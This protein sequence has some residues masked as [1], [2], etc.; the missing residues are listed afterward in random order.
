MTMNIRKLKALAPKGPNYALALR[1]ALGEASGAEVLEAYRLRGKGVKA[2]E[3]LSFALSLDFL[4]Q[5]PKARQIRRSTDTKAAKRA[6]ANEQAR[7][8]Y[9]R[10]F[11]EGLNGKRRSNLVAP[12][13]LVRLSVDEV[14]RMTGR[15]KD[16]VLQVR[17]AAWTENSVPV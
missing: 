2:E 11:A 13:A 1:V 8:A 12:E 6:F 10:A 15:D 9:Y 16:F 14:C 4:G 3:A 5:P 17:T 7:T